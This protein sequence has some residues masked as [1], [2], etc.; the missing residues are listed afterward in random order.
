M[1]IFNNHDKKVIEALCK[2]SED[3]SNDISKEIHEFLDDLKEEYD[4][5]KVVI[6]EFNTFVSEL[7]KKL[8]PEDIEKLNSFSTRL[9]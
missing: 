8:S 3:I 1:G 7:S 9:Y 2:K 5:N 4:Q 6:S